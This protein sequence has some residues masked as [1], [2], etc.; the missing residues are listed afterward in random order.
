MAFPLADL[1]ARLDEVPGLEVRRVRTRDELDTLARLAAANW[2]PADR[3]VLTFYDRAAPVLLD[4]A[5]PQWFFLGYLDG[6][7]VATAEAAV[8]AGTVAL[9]GIATLPRFR[10]R[11]IGSWMTWQPLRDASAAGCD[12]A[13][14]QAADEGV[15]LYRRLGF[16]AF[17]EI[18]EYKPAHPAR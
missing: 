1:P 14:L 5:C 3:D 10:N 6:E 17:G 7:P 8:H 9:F 13:T 4:P 12:L 2:I 16:A 11:G 18:T 15:G